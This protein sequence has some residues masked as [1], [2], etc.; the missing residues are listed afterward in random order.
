LAIFDLSNAAGHGFNMSGTSTNGWAYAEADPSVTTQVTYDDGSLV[1]FDIY[2]SAFADQFGVTYSVVADQWTIFDLGYL[3]NG[4][5][6]LTVNDLYLQT[7][8]ADLQ[9]GSWLIRVNAGNDDFY[10]NDFQDIIRAGYGND[11]VVGYAGND[12]L[13]GDQGG[14]ELWGGLGNDWLDGGVGADAM[15]GNSGNDTYVVDS[16]YDVVNESVSGSNGVDTVRSSISFNLANTARVLGA[17]ENLTLLGSGGISGT[18]N[19]LSNVIIGNAGSNVLNGAAGNDT[20]IG[21]AGTDVL[22]G[23]AGNDT[24]AGGAGYDYFVFNT[25]PNASNNI[26]RISDFNVVQDTIRLEN[27]VM[28]GL[29]SHVG[30]LSSAAFWKSTTGLAHDGNDRVVYETDTGWLNYDSNGSSAGGA[31][32]IALLNPNLALSYADFFVI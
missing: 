32:H 10:G 28:P 7:T 20:L 12:T 3:K 27:A 15:L 23:G 25:V 30:T 1:I 11:L 5:V 14:D 24:L 19:A 26:D 4:Q 9:A 22:Y 8:T 2:G 31:V 21:G 13:F 18:G 17:V 6:I 16:A 29:G